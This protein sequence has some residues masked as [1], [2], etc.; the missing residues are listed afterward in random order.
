MGRQ[1]L[2]PEVLQHPGL[3]PGIVALKIEQGLHQENVDI[4]VSLLEDDPIG[5]VPDDVV[6]RLLIQFLLA[7]LLERDPAGGVGADGP[8]ECRRQPHQ[9]CF[10]GVRL[11]VGL[12]QRFDQVVQDVASVLVGE[13]GHLQVA[14]IAAA[15]G[16]DLVAEGSHQ[17]RLAASRFSQE[18]QDSACRQGARCAHAI[19]RLRECLAHALMDRLHV[20]GIAPPDVGAVGDRVEQAGMKRGAECRHARVVVG[21]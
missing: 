2:A 10:G 3:D 5:Q 7:K 4:L 6:E 12:I 13:R 20:E 15:G 14:A 11:E 21:T 1:V 19:D 17:V 18:Q 8:G 9:A 16:V